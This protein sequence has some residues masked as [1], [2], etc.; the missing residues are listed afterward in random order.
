M[1]KYA[2]IG[3]GRFGESV[4][5]HLAEAGEQVLAVDINE[6]KVREIATSVFCAVCADMRDPGDAA[7]IGLGGLDAV[8]VAMSGS[9]EAS[10]TSV[11]L[12]K[13]AGVPFVLAKA[14]DDIQSRILKKVGADRV[15]IPE[16]E[17]GERVA[18]RLCSENLVDFIELSERIVLAE[19]EIRPEWRGKSLAE[20]GL[21][22]RLGFNVIGIREGEEFT[23]NIDPSKPLPDGGTVLIVADAEHLSDF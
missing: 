16:R 23:V 21:R 3:L 14:K 22:K 12:A 8:I 5:R 2:V 19:T 20:L 18:R 4:A 11:I 13:E 6:E 15:M 17:S 10:V 1:K 9:L 7:E